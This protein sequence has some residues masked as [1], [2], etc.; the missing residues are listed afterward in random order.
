MK[1]DLDGGELEFLHG[2]SKD[3]W[4]KI[5]SMSVEVDLFDFSKTNKILKLIRKK[6]PKVIN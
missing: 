5:K 2:I 1:I 6:K 4:N 3:Q